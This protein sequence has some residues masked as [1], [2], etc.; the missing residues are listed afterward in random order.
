MPISATCPTCS[1]DF[2]VKDEIAGKSFR[3]KHCGGT[4]KVDLPRRSKVVEELPTASGDDE[5]WGYDSWSGEDADHALS[6]P[7]RRK[8]GS[9]PQRN[10]Q[11]ND[12][13]VMPIE[14]MFAIGCIAVLG[15]L[16]LWEL[17][18]NDDLVWKIIA[19]VRLG[20]EARVVW[21]IRQRMDQTGIAAT[22]A[23]VMMT[24]ISVYALFA[25]A[26][27]PDLRIDMSA[28]QILLARIYFTAQTL[29]EIGVIV[30]LNLPRTRAFLASR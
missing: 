8:G 17:A 5:S 21:G 26:T 14:A 6:A 4:V 22:I 30:G 18:S 28:R 10:A 11:P 25:L 19:F 7:P 3:C 15:F 13:S 29:A 20:V 9:K 27:D 24:L 12:P 2:L 1:H 23:A 16:N